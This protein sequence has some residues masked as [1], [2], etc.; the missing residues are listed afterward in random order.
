MSI[1][2]NIMDKIWSKKEEAPIPPAAAVNSATSND[3][4]S[5]AAPA[6]QEQP[7]VDVNKILNQLAENN[8]QKLNW[9]V[10]IVDLMKLVGIE[11]S[12]SNRKELATELGYDGDMSDSATMNIW[13]HKAVLKKL[14]ENGG[15]VPAELL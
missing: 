10:S 1:F 5:N 2:S 4:T 6:A 12:L 9:K 7:Q 15:Q 11:S 3:A 8:D 13:L 14:S